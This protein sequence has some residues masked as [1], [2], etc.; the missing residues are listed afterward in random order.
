M[1][2]I[3]RAE[4]DQDMAAGNIEPQNPRIEEMDNPMDTQPDRDMAAGNIEPQNPRIEEMDNPMDNSNQNSSSNNSSNRSNQSKEWLDVKLNI[5]KLNS[6][7]LCYLPC[8]A[9]ASWE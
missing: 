2:L 7:L 8:L 5:A 1:S 6:N 9:T 4:P 3:P